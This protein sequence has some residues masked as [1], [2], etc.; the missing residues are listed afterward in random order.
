MTKICIIDYKMGNLFSIKRGLQRANAE[1]DII[2]EP[3]NK[4]DPTETLSFIV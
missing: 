3:I 2:E 1:V 4:F